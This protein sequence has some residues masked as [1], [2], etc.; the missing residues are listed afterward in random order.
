MSDEEPQR[1]GEQPS[2]TEDIIRRIICE[3]I[4]KSSGSSPMTSSTTAPSL[5]PS[6]GQSGT[7]MVTP[8]HTAPSCMS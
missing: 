1:I 3:E 6:E 5:S 2:L 8:S 4:A 7:L